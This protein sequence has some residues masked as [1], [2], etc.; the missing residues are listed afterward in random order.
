MSHSSG[1]DTV[2]ACKAQV[3]LLSWKMLPQLLMVT[4]EGN[5]VDG[6]F[7]YD[8]GMEAQRGFA[9]SPWSHSSLFQDSKQPRPP[10]TAL[11]FWGPAV[12]G[13]GASCHWILLR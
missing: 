8:E 11:T 5:W 6:E 7:P 12:L 2:W 1:R 13:L 10:L 3:L 4:L 9:S